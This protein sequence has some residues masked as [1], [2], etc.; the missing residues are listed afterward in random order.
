MLPSKQELSQLLGSLYDAAADADL[1]TPFLQELAQSTRARSA[2]L[3][4]HD[5]NQGVYTIS[6]SWAVDPLA[7]RLYQEHYSSL[8][9]WA[10][11][12]L[13]KPAGVVCKSEELCSREEIRT[14]EIYNDLMTRYGMDYGMFGVIENSRSRWASVSLFRD[15]SGSAFQDSELEVLKFLD[16][17]MRRAFNLHFQFSGLKA[18]AAGFEKALDILPTG[19]IF[20]GAKGRI[21]FMNRSASAVVNQRD[22]LLATGEGLR[23]ERPSE[24]ASLTKTILEAV[25]PS[26]GI[27]LLGEGTVQVSRRTRPA[28]QIVVSPLRDKA[29]D[30]SGPVSAVAFVIDPLQRQRPA[31]DILRTLFGLSPAECRVAL[32][33]GDGRSPREISQTIGVSFN[34]VRSQ[35]KSIFAKTGAKRQGELIRLLLNYSGPA[36]QAR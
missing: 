36:I 17:H 20:F 33:L 9:V 18:L 34:T 32:L 35:M 28:L 26:N 29:I 16:P 6:R 10:Q 15:E 11:R 4:M 1:W 8:D 21:V 5:A 25:S 2:L 12:G 23:A 3:L 27:G 24:S 31:Q 22:G 19:I 13:A 30:S 7:A 14:T